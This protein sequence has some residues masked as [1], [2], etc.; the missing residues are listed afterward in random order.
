M[1]EKCNRLA[2]SGIHA[3][4]CVASWCHEHQRS[5]AFSE[6]AS[7]SSLIFPA[8]NYVGLYCPSRLY[9]QQSNDVLSRANVPISLL[10]AVVDAF[11]VT[12]VVAIH[13]SMASFIFSL[14]SLGAPF[15]A[16]KLGSDQAFSNVR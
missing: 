6:I 2:S 1:S 4:V 11:Q 13:G 7:F 14:H 9:C 10:A 12:A 5:Y 8:S 15:V 3:Q 16:A